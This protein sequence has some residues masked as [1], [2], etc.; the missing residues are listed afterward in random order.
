MLS[1]GIVPVK[2]GRDGTIRFLILR[3]YA[4][5]DFPKGGVHSGEDPLDAAIRELWEET[6][7][8]A[9]E[10]PWGT[11]YFETEPYG[12]SR[13]RSKIARYYLGSVTR[14]EVRL[15]VAPALGIPEHHE[16]RWAS[17]SEAWN[18]LGP[19][20]RK[21]LSWALMKLEASQGVA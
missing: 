16:F 17:S 13:R 2:L 10:F 14:G 19:R 5:W 1:A 11:D 12:G 20:L 7:L 3:C 6:A 18:L 8:P 21:V 4:Y 9:P 15:I